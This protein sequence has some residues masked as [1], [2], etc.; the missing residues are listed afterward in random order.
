MP[1]GG[2]G[3]LGR[4]IPGVHHKR[5]P[6][7]EELRLGTRVSDADDPLATVRQQVQAAKQYL[8]QVADANAAVPG[9]P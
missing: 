2:R 1:G 4:D 8:R 7:G 6:A 5:P 9:R 3:P